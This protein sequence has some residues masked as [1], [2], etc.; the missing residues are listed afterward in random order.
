MTIHAGAFVKHIVMADY[1]GVGVGE[2]SV[3]V[4]RFAAEVLRL[5]GRVDADRDGLY[6]QFFE[7]L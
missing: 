2:E 7:I 3:R 4:T 1:F 5:R 6:S